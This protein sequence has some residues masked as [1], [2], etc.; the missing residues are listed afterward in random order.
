MTAT[1]LL[2]ALQGVPDEAKCRT[3][4]YNVAGWFDEFSCCV[5]D[6]HAAALQRDAMVEYLH[7]ADHNALMPEFLHDDVDGLHWSI[8]TNVMSGCYPTGL[9][10]LAAA[11][12][13]VAGQTTPPPL[14]PQTH[15]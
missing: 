1:E 7:R 9:H 8:D 5:S 3:I 13:Y 15:P 2:E 10:A 12:R 6:D 14:P 11:C 4:R